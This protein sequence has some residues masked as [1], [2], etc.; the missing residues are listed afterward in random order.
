[1]YFVVGVFVRFRA[2]LH[3]QRSLNEDWAS[4]FLD[5]NLVADAD[6]D[7]TRF[8]FLKRSINPCLIIATLLLLPTVLAVKSTMSIQ[9]FPECF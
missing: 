3:T 8:A 9:R 7:N 5:C 2:P 4:H 1:L 6:R